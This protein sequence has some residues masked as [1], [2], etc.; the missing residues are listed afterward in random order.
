[1]PSNW[2]VLLNVKSLKGALE[3]EVLDLSSSNSSKI[4]GREEAG[5]ARLLGMGI[6]T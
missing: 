5:D 3:K 1:M 6:G 4:K 2:M